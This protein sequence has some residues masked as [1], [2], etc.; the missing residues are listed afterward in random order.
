MSSALANAESSADPELIVELTQ[1]VKRTTTA[2]V[3]EIQKI[4]GR[5]K[6]LALNALIEAARAGE[7][8]R[9]FSV[10]AN[11]V[12]SISEEVASIARTLEAELSTQVASLDGLGRRMVQHV[13]GQRLVDLA[14][15]AI[16][17]IDRNLYERTCD[18]RWWA[19]DSAVVACAQDPSPE[20]CGFASQRLG[21]ILAAYTVYLDLWICDPQGK[22]IATGR[23]QR[24]PGAAGADVRGEKWFPDSLATRSGDDYAVADIAQCRQLDHAAVATYATAIRE[25]GSANGKVLGVL[26]VHFD[27]GAQAQTVVDGVRLSEEERSSTR[28]LLIDASHRV[29]AASDRKGVLSET[30]PLQAEGRDAGTYVDAQGGTIGF[31][32]TPGYE[33]YRGLGWYGCL[34]Q[35]RRAG[36]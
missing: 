5:T 18:V 33:T 26:A 12:K 28:V 35:S 16:E 9:G 7:A 34:V 6:I 3:A 27:W 25:G 21:V 11:E 17:I 29:I 8:G 23:P 24:Y 19:T 1:D 36:R 30:F 2:K 31:S 20:S 22:V 32:R 15:N 14:L 10:V 4:T 13:R